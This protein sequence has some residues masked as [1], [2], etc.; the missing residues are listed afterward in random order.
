MVPEGLS[1]NGAMLKSRAN[2][3]DE[4]GYV[5]IKF[6]SMGLI[7]PLLIL[8]F[9]FFGKKSMGDLLGKN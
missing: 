3:F 7:F 4:M 6:S 9:I 5:K 8:F 2:M 1:K